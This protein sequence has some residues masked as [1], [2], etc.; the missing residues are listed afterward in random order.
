MKGKKNLKSKVVT[1]FFDTPNYKV[2][3]IRIAPFDDL[4][5]PSHC[6]CSNE[7]SLITYFSEYILNFNN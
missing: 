3:N 1:Y 5:L 2:E 6:K 7:S 4:N